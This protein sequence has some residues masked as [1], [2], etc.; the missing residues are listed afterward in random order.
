MA[1]AVDTGPPLAPLDNSGWPSSPSGRFVFLLDAASGLEK[2][3]L[4]AWIAEHRPGDITDAD[5]DSIAIPSSRRGGGGRDGRRKVL[6]RDILLLGDPR[7]PGRLRQRWIR[8]REPD[9][10][11][12]VAGEPAPASELRERWRK[13]CGSTGAETL[14]LADFV[15]RQAALALER[16][17]RRLRGTR[18]KVPRFV[19][20]EVLTRPQFR[21]GV[22]R[23]ARS[24]GHE[25]A[26]VT[27][28]A[29]RY[30]KEIA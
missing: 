17:E 20:R 14:G 15:A 23:L 10:C 3:L 16:A 6:F 4:E 29:G 8:A 13:A 30:L 9:R 25:A 11:R 24:V 22:E 12:V 2:K 26:A 19:H 1:E 28:T 18:Y 27:K 7:D 21:G 5:L